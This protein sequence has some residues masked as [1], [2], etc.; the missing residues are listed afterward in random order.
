MSE[1]LFKKRKYEFVETIMKLKRLPKVWEFSFTDG[2]DQRLW[3]NK[4][5]KLDGK[6]Y[7]LFL[8]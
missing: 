2:E 8:E 1:S 5:Y 6:N 3:F 7:K 4:V